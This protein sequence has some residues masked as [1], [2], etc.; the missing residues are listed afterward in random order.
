MYSQAVAIVKAEKRASISYVQRRLRI[1]YNKAANFIEQME[2]EG[3][4][5][6]PD[7]QGKRIVIDGK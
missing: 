6:A 1:G 4:V 2:D 5:S 3:I 7:S